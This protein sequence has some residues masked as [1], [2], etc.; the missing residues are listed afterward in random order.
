M[1]DEPTRFRLFGFDSGFSQ[2]DD[3]DEVT[4]DGGGMDA[5]VEDSVDSGF[6]QQLAR[7]PLT[8]FLGGIVCV[9]ESADSIFLL[10]FDASSTEAITHHDALLLDASS[11]FVLSCG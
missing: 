6:A 10:L 8:F 4:V 2:S 5:K 11:C 7:A 1:Y 9:W 3:V